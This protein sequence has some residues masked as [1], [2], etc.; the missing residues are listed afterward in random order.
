M[1]VA[2]VSISLEYMMCQKDEINCKEANWIAPIDN[3]GL[4]YKMATKLPR[5]TWC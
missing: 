5:T 2:I 1:L 3:F 4:C